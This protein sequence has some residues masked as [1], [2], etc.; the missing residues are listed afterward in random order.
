MFAQVILPPLVALLPVTCFLAVLLWLDSYKLVRL[1]MVAA[2]VGCGVIA[3]G[4]SFFAGGW[5]L[6]HAHG[7]ARD[8]YSHWIA[9][10]LEEALKALVV[11]VLVRTHR[12]GFLV[13]A[14]ICGFAV[15]TGFALL[16]NVYVLRHASDVASS[17]WVARGFGT[18]LMHG[19]ATA[20][21]A[22]MGLALL[23][24][25]PRAPLRAFAPGLGLAIAL[26]AAFNQLDDRPKAATLA[27]LIVLPPLLYAVF[28]RSERALGD[29]LGKG[30]DAD[31]EML[32]LIQSGR[33]PESPLGRY[34]HALRRK[35]EGPVLADV[36]CYVRLHTELALRAKG[37]LMLRENGFEIALDEETRDKLDELRY[38]QQSIGRTGLRALQP[39]LR[40]SRR[41]LWQLYMVEG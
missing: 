17:T 21:F 33:F 31:A 5:L 2:V 15:G 27:V 19:G 35:F 37:L 11:L 40:M 41:D 14:A 39:A 20:I 8:D 30:F 12:V 1:P 4:A 16:E 22:V 6:G 7:L 3:A 32:A 34:L 23:E 36:L 28:H 38:L 13:D 9:P 25:S 24:R 18:A 10:P 26:H 29:W